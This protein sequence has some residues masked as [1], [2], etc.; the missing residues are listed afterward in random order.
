MLQDIV[1][2]NRLCLMRQ[3]SLFFSHPNIDE[4]CLQDFGKSQP[5]NREIIA[6]TVQIPKA[7][8][9]QAKKR[10]LTHLYVNISTY[11]KRKQI[12]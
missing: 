12:V 3:D 7:D 9:K 8:T 6:S 10:I 5:I 11:E 4:S 2:I 1:R